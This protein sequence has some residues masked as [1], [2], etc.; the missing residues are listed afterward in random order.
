[1]ALVALYIILLS[2]SVLY[3][4]SSYTFYPRVAG[5]YFLHADI[6]FTAAE[7]GS[8]TSKTLKFDYDAGGT[9]QTKQEFDGGA[10]SMTRLRYFDG[11]V[12]DTCKVR[13]VSAGAA[14]DI[15]GASSRFIAFRMGI[16]A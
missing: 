8:V 14:S 5:W 10:I 13:A 7:G 1:M 2:Y 11:S 12:N 4:T 6:H 16:T 15:L 3:T 9:D